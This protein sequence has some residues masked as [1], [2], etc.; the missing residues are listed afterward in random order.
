[1]TS[2]DYVKPSLVAAYA[3][4]GLY[5]AR[6]LKGSS[7]DISTN[8]LGTAA[9]IGFASAFVAPIVSTKLICPKDCTSGTKN[10]AEAASSAAVAWAAVLA[11]SDMDS[12]NM[13]V[14]VQL[15]SHLVANFTAPYVQSWMVSKKKA[16]STA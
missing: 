4:G 14:P 16:D 10:L 13:F 15:G 3:A 8:A 11:M 12:A 6:Y 5:V 9:A 7:E 1:M 2:M